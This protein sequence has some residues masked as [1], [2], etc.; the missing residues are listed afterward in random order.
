[1][2]KGQ[3][4]EKEFADVTITVNGGPKQ[5]QDIVA[6]CQAFCNRKQ[7]PT[8]YK[9][10]EEL[11]TYKQ[12]HFVKATIDATAYTTIDSNGQASVDNAK[13]EVEKS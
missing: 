4:Q 3:S 7:I 9:S 11:E 2:F 8:M 5:V 6:A 13:K 10:I 12:S 1:M